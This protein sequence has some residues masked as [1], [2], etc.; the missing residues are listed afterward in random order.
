MNEL[1]VY[2]LVRY[3]RVWQEMQGSGNFGSTAVAAVG[4]WL[5]ICWQGK[6]LTHKARPGFCSLEVWE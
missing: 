3:C 1:V 4:W 6:I 5:A 2:L